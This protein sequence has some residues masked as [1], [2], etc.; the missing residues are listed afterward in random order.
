M[1][2]TSFNITDVGYHYIGIRVL[3][4]MPTAPR[5]E[6]NQAIA[7]NALKYARDKALRLMLPEP[8]SSFDSVGAKV[9]QELAHFAFALSVKGRGYELT[10]VGKAALAMLNDKKHAAL[11]RTMALVHLKTYDNLRTV[12]R[13]TIAQKAIYFPNIESAHVGDVDYITG[14]LNPTLG[15]TARESATAIMERT[16][17]QSPKRVEDAL[18]ECVLENAMPEISIGVP[19]YRSMTDRLLSLRL[20]NSPRATIGKCEFSKNYSPCLETS[21]AFKWHKHLDVSLDGGG[22]YSLFLSEPEMG[23]EDTQREF[24]KALD[25]ALASLP[26]QAGYYD[27]PGVRDLVC[28][29]LLIPEAAFDEGVNALLDKKPP[30]I[31]VGL[32]YERISGRRKAAGAQPRINTN[33]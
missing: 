33:L 19:I 4:A 27:L 17:G 2:I 26:E 24:L 12:V 1:N 5:E 31:T 29:A 8:K 20:I 15:E 14:L 30:T 18:R 28:E 6:Q 13:S 3:A 7:R 11:R 16:K 9:C 22:A 21:A 25:K 23:D 32:T 10:D